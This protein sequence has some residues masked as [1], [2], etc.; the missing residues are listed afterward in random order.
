MA[1]RAIMML[2]TFCIE[3]LDAAE[4][5]S[6]NPKP[7]LTAARRHAAG[8]PA[9][10]Q[11]HRHRVGR[12]GAHRD[13]LPRAGRGAAELQA[14]AGAAGAEGGARHAPGWARNLQPLSN[15]PP[16]GIMS[17]RD[18]GPGQHR[19]LRCVRHGKEAEASIP[20]S[21]SSPIRT[22]LRAKAQPCE[23]GTRF[24]GMATCSWSTVAV[25][26]LAHTRLLRHG[27]STPQTG[28]VTSS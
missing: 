20:I 16:Q 15:R 8:R 18:G 23:S 3:L 21:S 12:R 5:F 10:G 7:S 19:F 4:G 1:K 13:Q 24:Y 2:C 26:S 22:A 9:G 6:L 27:R 28:T 11:R 25:T 14:R 17:R